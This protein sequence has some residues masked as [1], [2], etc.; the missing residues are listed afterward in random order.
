M[1]KIPEKFWGDFLWIP[2]LSRLGD[3][4]WAVK[5]WQDSTKSYYGYAKVTYKHGHKLNPTLSQ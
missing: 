3:C 1:F 5:K 2:A 4:Q